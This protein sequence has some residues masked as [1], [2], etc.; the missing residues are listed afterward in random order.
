MTLYVFT[1]VSQ[2]LQRE[3]SLVYRVKKRFFYEVAASTC[4]HRHDGKS[5][6][7]QRQNH[8]SPDPTRPDSLFSSAFYY[9]QTTRQ[10]GIKEQ[11]SCFILQPLLYAIN[12]MRQKGSVNKNLYCFSFFVRFFFPIFTLQS[13]SCPCDPSSPIIIIIIII[14]IITL[15]LLVKRFSDESIS[16]SSCTTLI[17]PLRSK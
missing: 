13:F 15:L 9:S 6:K 14:I 2:S 4:L 10:L 1:K 12:K 3:N 7:T 11:M 8:P 16:Q 17:A 5:H